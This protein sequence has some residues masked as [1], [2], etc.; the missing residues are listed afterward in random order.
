MAIYWTKMATC[1][2]VTLS[3][4]LDFSMDQSR[5]FLV[6]TSVSL[7]YLSSSGIVVLIL[8]AS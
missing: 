7:S 8:L 2:P 4:L 6:L 3:D 5:L 1:S